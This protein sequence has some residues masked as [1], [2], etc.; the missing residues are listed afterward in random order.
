MANLMDFYR[1]VWQAVRNPQ[2]FHA[3]MVHFPI[4]LSV[5]GV[6]FAVLVGATAGKSR[7]IRWCCILLYML[8]VGAAV[9]TADAGGDAADHISGVGVT[10]SS[11]AAKTLHNHEEMGDK[12]WI[13]MAVTGVFALGTLIPRPGIRILA[14][15]LLLAGSVA[16]A[17]WVSATAH[18]GGTMVYQHGVGVPHTSN[19]LPPSTPAAPSASP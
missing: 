13:F 16:T 6:L 17:G 12:V 9:L 18:F 15:V 1:S 8:G 7:P 2:Q 3:M 19:N 11:Q 4:V 5:L 14:I 10:L